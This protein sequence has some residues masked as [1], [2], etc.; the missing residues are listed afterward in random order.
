MVIR[1]QHGVATM[2][3]DLGLRNRRDILRTLVLNGLPMFDD[4]VLMG[5]VTARGNRNG[6]SPKDRLPPVRPQPRHPAVQRPDINSGT[7]AATLLA[8]LSRG[9]V[10]QSRFSP[11][12]RSRSTGSSPGAFSPDA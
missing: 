6:Q 8:L 9:E 1:R 3:N 2:R 4:D 5:I 12:I 11:P 7:H 10:A